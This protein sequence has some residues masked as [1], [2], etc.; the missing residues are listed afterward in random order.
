MI[1]SALG[2]NRFDDDRCDGFRLFPRE[3]RLLHLGQRPRFGFGVLRGEFAQGVFEQGEGHGG[4]GEGGDVELRVV[5][6]ERERQGVKE[7][8]SGANE[9]ELALCRVPRQRARPI[10]P[11]EWV[12]F[13]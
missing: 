6:G 5:K 12:C 7:S 11:C 13:V 1:I 2:L 8:G 10:A 4:P 3:D 9:G